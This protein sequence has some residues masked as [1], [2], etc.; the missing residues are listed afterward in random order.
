MFFTSCRLTVSFFR[1][2]GGAIC[3][4]WK[5]VEFVEALHARPTV[6][7]GNACLF[8]PIDWIYEIED[9]GVSALSVVALSVDAPDMIHMAMQ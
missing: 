7:Q 3:L 1:A 5:H 6:C 4:H 9:N 8:H 2:C